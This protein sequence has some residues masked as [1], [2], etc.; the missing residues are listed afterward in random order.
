MLKF[1]TGAMTKEGF[2]TGLR[3]VVFVGRSNVGKSSLLNAVYGQRIAYVGKKPGMTKMINFFSVDDRYYAVDVPGYG[4]AARSP[5]GIKAF[6]KM[7][8]DYFGAS[9]RIALVV[10]IVDSRHKPTRDDIDM[11]DLLRAHHL[12]VVIVAS[13]LD[14]LKTN[15][16]PKQIDLIAAT[17]DVPKTSI[18]KTSVLKKKGIDELRSY[19]D[20]CI[21]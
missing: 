7:M 6:G 4:Y 5:E 9:E 18:I 19:I 8:D 10:M 21:F 11:I 15:D 14:K 1:I 16:I 13:K 2:P 17:L 3:D 20:A 12:K